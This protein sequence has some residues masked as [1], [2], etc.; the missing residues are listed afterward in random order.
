MPDLPQAVVPTPL[1]RLYAWAPSGDR[2]AA[3]TLDPR[4][5]YQLAHEQDPAVV[6]VAEQ[7]TIH[8]VAYTL[9]LYLRR[10]APGGHH[11][12]A[13]A[14]DG[15]AVDT[16]ATFL[17]RMD[18]RPGTPAAYAYLYR[19]VVPALAAWAASDPG[20]RLL[21]QGHR[22]AT[23]QQVARIT[24]AIARKE[25]ELAELRDQLARLER[26]GG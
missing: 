23:G 1:G 24:A 4:D 22:Y 20:R 11:A 18:G 13:A 12:A 14:P 10:V 9:R 16:G 2:L 7:V 17:G 3:A 21:A 8:G 15:W 19:V 26:Q 25:A 5:K 6:D